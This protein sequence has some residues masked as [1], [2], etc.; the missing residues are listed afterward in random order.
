MG[1]HRS[2]TSRVDVGPPHFDQHMQ[3]DECAYANAPKR[4]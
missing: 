3:S 1:L 2:L 4:F